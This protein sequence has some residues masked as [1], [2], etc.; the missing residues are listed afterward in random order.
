MNQD[1]VIIGRDSIVHPATKLL[2]KKIMIGDFMRI[3]SNVTIAGG[4]A[5]RRI[6]FDYIKF[7]NHRTER[8]LSAPKGTAH[9]P[10]SDLISYEGK[11]QKGTGSVAAH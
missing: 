3:G 9:C 6:R 4:V 7:R 2:A 8:L 11:I 10:D 5:L 1:S